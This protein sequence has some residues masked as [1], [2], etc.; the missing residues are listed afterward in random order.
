[1]GRDWLTAGDADWGLYVS[2]HRDPATGIVL[3]EAQ[4]IAAAEEAPEATNVV[5]L[6]KVLEGSLQAARSGR[7]GKEPA[8]ER[9]VKAAPRKAA[10]RASAAGKAAKTPTRKAPPKKAGAARARTSGAGGKKELQKLSKAELYQ[11]ATERDLLGRSKMSREELIDALARS[12][13]RRKKTAA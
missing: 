11:R 6:M 5:D 12:G 4:E 13:R 8:D 9:K 1:M 10:A 3:A 2:V 7:G